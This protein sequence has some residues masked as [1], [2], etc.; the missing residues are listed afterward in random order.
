MTAATA[1]QLRPVLP[2]GVET[3]GFRKL[4]RTL[5]WRQGEH[6]T[7]IG[8]TGAGKTLVLRHLLRLRDYV[9]VFGVKLEDESLDAFVREGYRRIESWPPA[10]DDDR[11]ILWPRFRDRADAV[12]RGGQV[13]RSA[14]DEI[15]A[16]R[17]WT[18]AADELLW[19]DGRLGMRDQLDDVWQLGRSMKVTLVAAGQRPYG[20]PRLSLSQATHLVLWGT[21][22]D[23]DLR[24]LA[25][26]S[27][28]VDKR[29]LR[30]VLRALPRYA[31]V[32]VNARTGRIAV[33]RLVP[34]EV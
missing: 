8:P 16:E 32:Y 15:A 27:G 31:F 20:V 13:F 19:L 4:V 10:M 3:I 17:G 29:T 11:V 14:L 30:D 6:L 12:E 7:L 9:V 2:A 18:V 1:P 28:P 23:D 25:E 21:T 24:R 22:D 34:V 5:D 26:I 33:S